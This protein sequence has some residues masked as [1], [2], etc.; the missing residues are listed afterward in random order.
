MESIVVLLAALVAAVT[1]WDQFVTVFSTSGAGPVSGRCYRTVWRALLWLHQRRAIHGALR[2]AGPAMILC[3]ILGWYLL[4]T[5]AIFL[6]LASHPGAVINGSTGEPADYLQTLYFANTTL[7]SLGYG[8]WVPAGYPWTLIS[9]LGTLMATI[10][11]TVSLSY[12][13]SVVSAAVQ[14][15]SLGTSIFALGNTPAEIIDS[16]RLHDPAGSLKNYLLN[17]SLSIDQQGLRHLAFPVLKYFHATQHQQSP[18]RGLLLLADTLFV[19]ELS[20]SASFQGLTRVLRSSIENFVG[21]SR[22]GPAMAATSDAHSEP[23]R[24]Y[25][26]QLAARLGARPEENEFADRYQEYHPLRRRLLAL[27]AEDGWATQ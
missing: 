8:D 3:S 6:M 27:C 26:R 4:L 18:A 12:V 15:R 13:L 11:L 17:L 24:E 7:S 20:Q 2:F 22:V 23:E 21:F 19:L 14:R 5:L 25:L 1:L 9:T 10:V 16:A